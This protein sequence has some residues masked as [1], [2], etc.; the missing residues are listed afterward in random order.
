MGLRAWGLLFGCVINITQEAE[1]VIMG[2]P[3]AYE[4]ILQDEKRK[5]ELGQITLKF[6]D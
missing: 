3:D 5:Q 4:S 6:P 2:S 1:K